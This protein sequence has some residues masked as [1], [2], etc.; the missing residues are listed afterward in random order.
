M[1]VYSERCAWLLKVRTTFIALLLLANEYLRQ[2]L[3]CGQR[4]ILV[5][6]RTTG[7]YGQCCCLLF[8][9]IIKVYFFDF[10]SVLY[11]NTEVVIN[12]VLRQLLTVNQHNFSVVFR[13]VLFC[14]FCK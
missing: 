13:D 11:G 8:F 12:H 14:I 1:I 10:I 7:I 2:K 3:R 9:K 5:Q 4:L 6:L